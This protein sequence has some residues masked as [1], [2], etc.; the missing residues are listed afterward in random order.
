MF[1]SK[2]GAQTPEG[3]TLCDNC[4]K[5]T[6]AT[7]TPTPT[8]TP[9]ANPAGKP[10]TQINLTVPDV[11]G[12]IEKMGIKGLIIAALSFLTVVFSILSFNNWFSASYGGESVTIN[13]SDTLES[14]IE[15][16][17]WSA[18]AAFA[19]IIMMGCALVFIIGLLLN[20][21]ATI[22]PFVNKFVRGAAVIST[23]ADI[24]ALVLGFFA[25]TIYGLAFSS[26]T[27]ASMSLGM[28][29]AVWLTVLLGIARTVVALGV[30]DPVLDSV[31]KK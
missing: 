17:N 12:I 14:F 31:L 21:V 18:G 20:V 13:L 29:W 22:V 8:V 2:C 19:A 23:A 6:V 1:C 30:L 10:A 4:A 25:C 16:G 26:A 5:A 24:I 15:A 27:G 3:K 7:A 9:A 28:G 11:N